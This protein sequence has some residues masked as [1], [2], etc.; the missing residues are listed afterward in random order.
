MVLGTREN[1][2]IEGLASV[3]LALLG[4]DERQRQEAGEL[5][6]TR[7]S[8][9]DE[10]LPQKQAEEAHIQH[11]T[12]YIVSFRPPRLYSKTLSKTKQGR[13]RTNS[14]KLI[15]THMYSFLKTPPTLCVCVYIRG[16]V[17]RSK[18]FAQLFSPCSPLGQELLLT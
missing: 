14:Q 9:R 6:H 8:R 13:Q 16:L 4:Q 11:K 2:C 10:T 15:S 1:S 18:C 12:N 7:N 5:D 3:T 17:Q